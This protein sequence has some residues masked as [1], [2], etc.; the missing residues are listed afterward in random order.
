M[1]HIKIQTGTSKNDQALLLFDEA[2]GVLTALFYLSK[3]LL[4]VEA[5]AIWLIDMNSAFPQKTADSISRLIKNVC[6]N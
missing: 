6:A 1:R 3:N 5:K 4:F 2:S